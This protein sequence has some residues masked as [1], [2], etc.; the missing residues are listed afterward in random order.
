MS[1]PLRLVI[2][3]GDPD[4]IGLEVT[5]KALQKTGPQ[6]GVNFIIWRSLRASKK[7]LSLIDKRFRRK[8][9]TSWSEALHHKF[10]NS[11]DIVDIRSSLLAPNWVETS[12]KASLFGHVDAIV[13]A[14]LSKTLIR[15]AG[16][17]GLGHTEILADVCKVER[18]FM[19][20]AGDKFNVVLATGHIPLSRVT[21]SLNSDVLMQAVQAADEMRRLLSGAKKRKPI[22]LLALNPHAGESGLIGSQEKEL[23]QPCLNRA[24]KEEIPVYDRLLV[25]DAAFQKENWDRFSVFVSMYHDQGLIPFKIVHGQT[26][27]IQITM[28]LPFI[29]TSVDHGTAKDIF[30]RDKANPDSMTHAIEWAVNLSRKGNLTA[31]E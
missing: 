24:F 12:A 27:G 26:S 2:T 31:K 9:V 18:L 15:E 7:Y 28:G 10:E 5:A 13:T 30:G 25:P 8:T 21:E 11:R 19:G 14:P 1:R 16:Y 23:L 4:G 6:P 29:R 22:A 3:T 17:P 20:F